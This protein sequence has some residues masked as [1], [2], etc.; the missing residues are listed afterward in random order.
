MCA[1][2]EHGRRVW[3]QFTA[4][5]LLIKTSTKDVAQALVPAGSRLVS[6]LLLTRSADAGTSAGALD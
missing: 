3:Y 1:S 2:K 4:R 6:I 5:G